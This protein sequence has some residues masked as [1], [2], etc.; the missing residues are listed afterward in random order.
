MDEG[1]LT[2]TVLVEQEWWDLQ[3]AD[4]ASEDKTAPDL[5]GLV[6]M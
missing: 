6:P 1:T 4:V 3:D 2:P 5:L